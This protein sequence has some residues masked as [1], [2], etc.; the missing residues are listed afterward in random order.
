MLSIKMCFKI[1]VE[2]SPMRPFIAQKAAALI[3][4]LFFAFYYNKL[5]ENTHE[6]DECGASEGVRHAESRKLSTTTHHLPWRRDVF[7]A[8]VYERGDQIY[9][10]YA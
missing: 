8:R 3:I 1:A 5:G 9:A 10:N 7:I 6:L 2:S 4:L